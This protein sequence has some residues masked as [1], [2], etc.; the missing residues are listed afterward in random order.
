MSKKC[1]ICNKKFNAVKCH[2]TCSLKCSLINQKLVLKNY[3]QKN[4]KRLVQVNKKWRKNNKKRIKEL[5]KKYYKENREKLIFKIKKFREENP[6]YCK[7][8][9]KNYR[10]NHRK[11]RNEYNRNKY[12][13]DIIYKLT[14]RL[15]GRIIK[16]LKRNSKS[17][18]TKQLIGC[19]I[20]QLK[21][22]LEKQF[23]NG[24]SW[25]NWGTGSNGKDK[26]EWH[27]DHLK[28]CA[29]FELSKPKEQ[30]KCFNYTNLQ[31]LWAYEN[32]KKGKKCL[33]Y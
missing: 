14:E 7:K 22:H 19:S 23:K 28:P 17:A 32:L 12:N 5:R 9:Q 31:P 6:L 15:R 10:K 3:Y 27:I 1:K 21:E 33:K 26:I 30:L 4:K 29:S 18:K 20:T 2:F 25:Q 24:M 16:A 11:Q 8:Y 13:S